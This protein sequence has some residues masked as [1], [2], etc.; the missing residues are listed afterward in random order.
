VPSAFF[1]ALVMKLPIYWV[2]L[3]VQAEEIVKMLILIYRVRS[4]KW[5]RNLVKDIS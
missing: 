5:L 1:F 4:L 2:L 3:I